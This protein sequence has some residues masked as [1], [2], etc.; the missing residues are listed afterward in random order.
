MTTYPNPVKDQ[1][2]IRV[3]AAQAATVQM[4][5]YDMVGHVVYQRCTGQYRCKH[6]D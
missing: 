6:A 2:D 5:I 4:T 1:L 3:N